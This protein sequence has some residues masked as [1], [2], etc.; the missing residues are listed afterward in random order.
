[1]EGEKKEFVID[2]L[3]KLDTVRKEPVVFK[4]PKKWKKKDKERENKID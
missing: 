3:E 2:F 1:M 4:L